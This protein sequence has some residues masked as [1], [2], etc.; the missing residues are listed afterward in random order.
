MT[1][2]LLEKE[3]IP[4]PGAEDDIGHYMHQIRQ[5]PLL[6]PQQERSLAMACARGDEDAIRTMVNSNLRLVVSV[7]REYVGRGVPLLDLIQEGSIG[8]LVAARKFDYTRNTRFSTYASKWIRQGVSRCILNHA[9]VIRVPMHTMEKMRKLLAVRSA[10]LQENC[11]EPTPQELSQKSGIEAD[12]VEKLLE[13]LPQICSLDAPAGE[14]DD[15]TLQMLLEDLHAPQPQEELVRRELKH[16][17]DR[18]L[19][20]LTPRQQEVLRLRFGMDD[21]VAMSL[22]QVADRLEIS[23]E[24]SRQIEQQALQRLKK[25]GTD[26]GLEDFLE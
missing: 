10:L 15:S 7:A 25:L 11:Q 1:Q 18:L 23:K 13:L 5:Y 4:Q 2:G 8:L 6:T 26:L 3:N 21:G 16:T 17:V 20:Q 24:R 14:N 22:Q 12:K 19:Q 9:G